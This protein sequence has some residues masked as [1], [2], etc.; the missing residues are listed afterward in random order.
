MNTSSIDFD[1]V[2]AAALRNGRSFVQD[3]LIPQPRG[4]EGFFG[5]NPL[6]GLGA[7]RLPEC[8]AASPMPESEVAS[9]TLRRAV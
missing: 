1:G 5:E 3:D 6:D 7:A 9:I 8:I 2:N 4:A